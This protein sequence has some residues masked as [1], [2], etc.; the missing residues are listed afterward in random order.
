MKAHSTIR[1]AS[2]VAMVAALLAS[3]LILK[4]QSDDSAKINELLR[5][6]KSHAAMA[7]HDA[8]LLQAYARTNVSWESHA[9]KINAMKVHINNLID[10]HNEM[11]RARETALPW[12]QKAI[13]RTDPL[14]K[15][16]ADRLN[17][18]I[19]HLN[20]NQNKVA[21]KTYRD[22]VHS[23]YKLIS[24]LDKMVSDFV[25]YEEAKSTTDTLEEKLELPSASTGEGS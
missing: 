24:T 9:N 19:E 7:T 23:N 11:I 18:T 10:D 1:I 13:D 2:K 4:A 8:D 16:I 22:Y 17:A 14:V 6:V 20:N 3:S 12:Q 15:E 21:L 5:S 25:D